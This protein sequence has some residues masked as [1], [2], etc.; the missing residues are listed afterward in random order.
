MSERKMCHDCPHIREHTVGDETVFFGDFVK[1]P[2]PCHN[3]LTLP[4]IGHMMQLE[5]LGVD[6]SNVKQGE[7]SIK[8]DYGENG[9]ITCRILTDKGPLPFMKES[10]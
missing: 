5:K 3:A 8:I 7:F 2:H 6:M 9:G 1:K 4:C 10:A